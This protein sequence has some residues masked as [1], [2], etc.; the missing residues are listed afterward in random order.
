M[1]HRNNIVK[2]ELL[3]FF[4]DKKT[5]NQF[6]CEV[7]DDI[8]HQI[9]EIQKHIT[10]NNRKATEYHLHK[11]LSLSGLFGM[12]QLYDSAVELVNNN[13]K[14]MEKEIYQSLISISLITKQQL[15]L[16]IKNNTED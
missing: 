15:D 9:T 10:S 6:L 7:I 1:K 14:L 5:K 8:D 16:I 12:E 2:E 4:K 11:I 3:N 13:D